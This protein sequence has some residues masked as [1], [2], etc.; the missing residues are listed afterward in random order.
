MDFPVSSSL[1]LC[2]RFERRPSGLQQASTSGFILPL[3]GLTAQYSPDC[4]LSWRHKPRIMHTWIYCRGCPKLRPKVEGSKGQV[5]LAARDERLLKDAEERK[6]FQALPLFYSFVLNHFIHIWHLKRESTS[7]FV[8]SCFADASEIREIERPKA[9]S[10]TI[11]KVH[12]WRANLAYLTQVIEKA[13][14]T[15]QTPQALAPIQ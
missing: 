1:L 2:L 14:T 9:E 12:K 6:S 8:V 3:L 13:P 15:L 4:C 11:S 7:V 5:K 10:D